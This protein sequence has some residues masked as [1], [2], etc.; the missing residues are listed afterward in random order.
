MCT[1]QCSHFTAALSHISRCS[2]LTGSD[3]CQPNTLT[4]VGNASNHSP[5]Y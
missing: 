3:R 1:L 2:S 5:R 4:C